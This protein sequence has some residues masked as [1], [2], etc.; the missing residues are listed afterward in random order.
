MVGEGF[1]KVGSVSVEVV[2][3]ATD[4]LPRNGKGIR[5]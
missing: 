3:M 1:G 5:D 4:A 2:G